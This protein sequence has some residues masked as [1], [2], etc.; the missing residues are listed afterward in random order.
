VTVRPDPDVELPLARAM[1]PD[2]RRMGPQLV[3]AGVLPVIGYA[4]LR[5]HVGSDATALAAVMV[6]PLID[7]GVARWRHGGF[8]PIGVISLIGIAVG[9]VGAVALHGNATLLKLR[10]SALTGAFGAVC[11]ASLLASRP[12]MF[13]VGRAFAAGGDPDRRASFG[14]I[15]EQPG[16]ARRFRVVTAV[17][18]LGLLGETALRTV[19]ALTISTETFLA[20]APVVGWVVIGALIAYSTY[21]IRVGEREADLAAVSEPSN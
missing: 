12:A 5:P 7:I 13:Y 18:G 10:E 16:A 3:M 17:W 21:V 2:F 4:L 8:E 6:F 20:F 15:W 14:E 19:L 11:L 9:L 1:V